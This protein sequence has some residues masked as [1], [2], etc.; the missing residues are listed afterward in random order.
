AFRS[1]HDLP[2]D[3]PLIGIVGRLVPVKN[4]A[5]FL[6]AAVKIKQRLPDARFAII[7]DGELRAE[8][9]AEASALGLGDCVVFT[10]WSRDV[11]P[12]YSDLDVLVI[13]SLNEGTPVSVI[14]A[15]AAGC[16]V[17]ATAVGGLPDLLDGGDLGTL[18]PPED[19]DELASAVVKTIA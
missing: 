1:A 14:E 9:E 17:V 11:A 3:A 12:V 15:L 13:S 2:A 8:L 4:H 18:V 7:G 10:G 19:A 16:P 6:R 5:L